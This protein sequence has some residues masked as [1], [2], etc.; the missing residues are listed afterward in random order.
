MLRI[1][2]EA[3][4][5]ELMEQV[6]FFRH[7]I[8]VQHLGWDE[9]RREDGRERDEYDTAD[10][11]HAILIHGRRILGYSRLIPTTRPHFTSSLH[12]PLTA[13]LPMGSDIFEWSRCATDLHKA[14]IGAYATSDLLMTGVLEC[15]V[16]LSARTILFVTCS[17]LIDMMKRRGYPVQCL[18]IVSLGNGDRA[19]IASSNLPHDLLA[20]HRQRYGIR[21]SL[22]AW[23]RDR[24]AF[25]QRPQA[26]A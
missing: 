26:A 5:P 13:K 7:Q 10:A 19:E 1:I 22:L 9:L 24:T 14:S 4:D 17:P 23:G 8:F 16:Q 21:R 6:W 15:L 11:I 25:P 18:D 2:H 3:D 12:R 20:R